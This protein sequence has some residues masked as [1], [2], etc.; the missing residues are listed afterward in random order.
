MKKHVFFIVITSLI[1]LGRCN[2]ID[3]PPFAKSDK[4]IVIKC[5]K[6]HKLIWSDLIC[7]PA[8]NK[9]HYEGYHI[10]GSSYVPIK[11]CYRTGANSYLYNLAYI[12]AY[13]AIMCPAPWRVPTRDDYVQSFANTNG[14]TLRGITENVRYK[15]LFKELGHWDPEWWVPYGRWDLKSQDQAPG[16]WGCGVI[17]HHLNPDAFFC[18]LRC[19]RD[20]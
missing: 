14:E 17:K 11:D 9:S 6:G 10:V 7:D 12:E 15:K 4:V 20:E 19:V 8:C 5:P 1:T 3:P 2:N 13:T 18:C 16:S